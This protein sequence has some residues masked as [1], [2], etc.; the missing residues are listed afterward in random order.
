[1]IGRTLAHSLVVDGVF[2]GR[3][4]CETPMMKV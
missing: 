2:C 4:L 1:M 3:Y